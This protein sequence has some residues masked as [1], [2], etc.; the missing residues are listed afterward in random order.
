MKHMYIKPLTNYKFLNLFKATYK[1]KL[2]KTRDWIFTSRKKTSRVFVKNYTSPDAVIIVAKTPTDSI[3]VIREYRPALGVYHYGLPAG[4]VDDNES[5][6]VA[7]TRELKE[8]TGLTVS[9]VKGIS[10]ALT[11]SAGMTDEMVSY[12]FVDCKGSI[13]TSGNEESEDI[14]VYTMSKEEVREL[15]LKDDLMMDVRAWPI[16]VQFANDNKLI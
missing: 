14:E 7:G 1:D 9:K 16:L 12:L 5:A 10:P 15:L 6:L 2:G 4:L 13:D 3:V 11:S 8:E